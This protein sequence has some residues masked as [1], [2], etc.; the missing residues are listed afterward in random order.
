MLSAVGISWCVWGV[1][2]VSW[3]VSTVE[4]LKINV[5]EISWV[6]FD[7]YSVPWE[8]HDACRGGYHEYHG[9]CQERIKPGFSPGFILSWWKSISRRK[10]S[11]LSFFGIGQITITRNSEFYFQSANFRY[12]KNSELSFFGTGQITIPW[13]SRNFAFKV[14]SLLFF[15]IGQI[16]MS[17][18][19]KFFFQSENLRYEKIP[20]YRFSV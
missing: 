9:R 13:N 10:N 20:S 4:N 6:L 15:G 3:G 2:W 7:V 16:T 5:G 19:S 18:N 17:R 8:I 1:F 14:K 11:E 12:E